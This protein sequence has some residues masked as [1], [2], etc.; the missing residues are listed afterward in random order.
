MVTDLVTARQDLLDPVGVALGDAT[1]HEEGRG[2]VETVHQ[3]EQQGDGDLRAVRAL[4]ERSRLVGVRRV[5]ADPHLL[6]VEVEADD[7]V[8]RHAVGAHGPPLLGEGERDA[9]PLAMTG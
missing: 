5:L 8:D 1:G 2:H 4:R 7:D 3:V 9:T 6:R